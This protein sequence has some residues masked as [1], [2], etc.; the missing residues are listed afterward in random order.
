M[1]GNLLPSHQVCIPLPSNLAFKALLSGDTFCL[2][3]SAQVPYLILPKGSPHSAPVLLI[4]WLASAIPAVAPLL[5]TVAQFWLA[6]GVTGLL[7]P[8]CC[9]A[10]SSALLLWPLWFWPV[11][12]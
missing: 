5:P 9:S 2:A 4:V 12:L 10:S 7:A 1:G 6:I 11:V 3:L 8:D